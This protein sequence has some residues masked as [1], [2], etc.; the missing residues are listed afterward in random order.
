MLN[1]AINTFYVIMPVVVIVGIGYISS[2]TGWIEDKSV[3]TLTKIVFYIG[4][5]AL[6]LD[7]ISRSNISTFFEMKGPVVVMITATIMG[8][9]GYISAVLKKLPPDQRGVWA[10]G[11]FRANMGF[12]GLPIV[13]NALGN[14]GIQYCSLILALGVP[15]FNILSV[16]FL[17]LPHRGETGK[18]PYFKMFIEVVKN[19]LV[20]SCILGVLFAFVRPKS[21]PVFDETLDYLKKIPL[22]LALLAIGAK[23]EIRRSI[24]LLKQT[25]IPVFYKIVL[26][27]LIGGILLYLL[28]AQ[29]MDFV[30]TTLLLA[31]PIAVMSYIMAYEMKGDAELAANLVLSTTF[32]SFFS[33]TIILFLLGLL[34]IWKPV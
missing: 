31:S 32:L 2:K 14:K 33:F 12:V 19:P 7:E 23:L 6:L 28:N 25:S 8:S 18:V 34:G 26:T 9:L 11:S 16:I 22:P 10:Q 21:L 4:L 15:V 13:L 30:S 24:E 27:P 29:P 3:N 5:P 20:I 17:Y 1:I